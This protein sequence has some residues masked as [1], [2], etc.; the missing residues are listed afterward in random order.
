M[1]NKMK[2]EREQGI[3]LIFALGV[4]ALLLIMMTAF[5]SSMLLQHQ[6]STALTRAGSVE[7]LARSA[8]ERAI[9]AMS[10]IMNDAWFN[11]T[12]RSTAGYEA[13][14]VSDM[15]DFNRVV[16][17]TAS[18]SNPSQTDGSSSD[19]GGSAADALAY[20]VGNTDIYKYDSAKGMDDPRWIYVR[21]DKN[22]AIV[23]R[24]AYAAIPN[25]TPK[26][27]INDAWGT[28]TDPRRGKS[29][30][31]I[32]L[33]QVL[34]GSTGD[35]PGGSG[36]LRTFREGFGRMLSENSSIKEEDARLYTMVGNATATDANEFY[37]KDVNGDGMVQVDEVFR[38]LDLNRLTTV[39]NESD[40][41]LRVDYLRKGYKA[42]STAPTN[43]DA[44][45]HA[46]YFDDNG[47]V[48][49]NNTDVPLNP[50]FDKFKNASGDDKGTFDTVED[51]RNQI[52]ANIIDFVGKSPFGDNTADVTS[53]VNPS[54]WSNLKR[55]KYTGNKKTYYINEVACFLTLNIDVAQHS[56]SATVTMDG[57]ISPWGEIVNIYSPDERD[58]RMTVYGSVKLNGT[59]SSAGESKDVNIDKNYKSEFKIFKA[60]EDGPLKNDDGSDITESDGYFVG[61]AIKSYDGAKADWGTPEKLDKIEFS[62]SLI[63]GTSA[64][65]AKLKIN[66]LE[67]TIESVILAPDDDPEHPVDFA[68][69]NDNF[70]ENDIEEVPDF[71]NEGYSFS[72]AYLGSFEVEDPRQ[73]LN[74]GDWKSKASGDKMASSATGKK[75]LARPNTHWKGNDDYMFKHL[76]L[77]SQNHPA[78][79]HASEI[80]QDV[81]N[82]DKGDPESS[83][84]V[85]AYSTNFIKENKQIESLWEL[86]AIH[87]GIKWQTINLKKGDL[88]PTTCKYSDGD[89]ELLDMVY[90]SS[91]TN[92]S[93]FDINARNM[94]SPKLSAQD[95]KKS[96]DALLNNILVSQDYNNLDAG[97][98]VSLTNSDIGDFGADGYV[99]GRSAIAEELSKAMASYNTDAEQES[100]FGRI[101]NIIEARNNFPTQVQLIVAAQTID[102]VGGIDSDG[103]G[104]GVSISAPDADGNVVTKT[105]CKIGVFDEKDNVVFDKIT[106]TTKMLV[107]LQR[108]IEDG[109]KLVVTDVEYI[110]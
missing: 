97:S 55:P 15:R 65:P 19:D 75:L 88:N 13:P 93:K 46:R 95:N 2:N 83:N 79:V 82:R 48:V 70:S 69:I 76:S 67:I 42:G 78:Y 107:T 61:A 74:P 91:G 105:D 33:L 99:A 51:L 50:F 77:G 52:A 27:N 89:A 37:W 64:A 14:K 98:A 56:S 12:L 20:K 81:N 92:S 1:N 6:N 85:R 29:I 47:K 40:P 32:D 104:V 31:D 30:Q 5:V 36:N 11:P 96:W 45:E 21:D 90:V 49:G 28:T 66:N 39:S 71:T 3:A 34:L 100:I 53:D 68:Y 80:Q 103:N 38:R 110:D 35:F 8:T 59:L 18:G 23:G 57:E 73:N 22:Q 7:T 72:M 25:F 16:S 60:P 41:T 108:R 24:Y 109:G 86:G 43:L 101:A 84:F 58:Y 63:P 9:A 106:A 54:E 10:Y 44:N 17:M 4:L 62:Y 26:I 94:Q 87:R 102:D